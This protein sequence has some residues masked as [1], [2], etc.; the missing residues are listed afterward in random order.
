MY[1]C[2]LLPLRDILPAVMARYSLFVLKVPLNPKQT[3]KQRQ[4][5]KTRSELV[6]SK[7]VTCDIFP[8]SAL[9]LSRVLEGILLLCIDNCRGAV[10]CNRE[11]GVV[12]CG[13]RQWWESIGAKDRQP[14]N[15]ADT[16]LA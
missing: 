14:S 9:T 12:G 2:Y 15:T 4:S 13:C 5:W 8:F 7:A 16:G 1:L 3:D 6:V 11:C 10:K